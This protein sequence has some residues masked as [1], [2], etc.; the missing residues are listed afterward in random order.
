MNCAAFDRRLDALGP[1]AL[2]AEA[3]AHASACERCARVLNAERKIAVLLAAPPAG[4]ASAD[5]TDRV[6]A[7]VTAPARAAH[8]SGAAMPALVADPRPFW[9]RLVAEPAVLAALAL[10]A[11]AV[12]ALVPTWEA[13]ATAGRALSAWSAGA[14]NAAAAA[15]PATAGTPARLAPWFGLAWLLALGSVPLLRW[16]ARLAA[17]PPHLR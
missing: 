13:A 9:A 6:L 10:A 14:W 12:V 1:N 7:R 3:L 11:L 4:R 2:G 16:V 15:A 5:F 17:A 8:P